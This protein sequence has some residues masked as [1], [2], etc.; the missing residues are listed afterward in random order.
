MP[1]LSSC[2]LENPAHG[3]RESSPVCALDGQ[4]LL[5]RGSKLI[6]TG[7]AAQFGDTPFRGDQTLVFQPV[8]RGVKR[9][10]I[11][12]EDVLGDLLDPFGDGPSVQAIRLQQFS[13]SSRSSIALQ[14]G[15]AGSR[16]A[17]VSSFYSNNV[18][19]CR[20]RIT[21]QQCS[22]QGRRH[23]RSHFRYLTV[24]FADVPRCFLWRER[25]AD[26]TQS[27]AARVRREEMTGTSSVT[28]AVL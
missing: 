5:S 8:Q 11:D 15:R 18:T 2:Q 3:A 13:K 16:V 24:E 19:S 9:S 1:A 25:H 28:K 27:A 12:L 26:R 7:S 21:Q 17:L 4:L 22:N 14:E 10:L 20:C 23:S 6:K